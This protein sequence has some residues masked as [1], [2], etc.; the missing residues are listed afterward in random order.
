MDNCRKPWTIYCLATAAILLLVALSLTGVI[1]P[2]P[3]EA[4][5]AERFKDIQELQA[6]IDSH[7]KLATL[8]N[9]NYYFSALGGVLLDTAQ[10]PTVK[11]TASSVTNSAAAP[12]APG[13]AP[14]GAA[15]DFSTTNNQVAGVDEAD[16]VKSDGSYLYVKSGQK[17]DILAAYPPDSAKVLSSLT[18]DNSPVGLFV[19]GSQLLVIS[20]QEPLM[21]PMIAVPNIVAP[22]G[23]AFRPAP[24][25]P[26]LKISV[27]DTA[28]KTAPRLKDSFAITGAD[29]V[30]S[31]MIG[32]YV[33]LIANTPLNLGQYQNDG[34][35]DVRL[36]EIVEGNGGVTT[37]PA[38]AIQHFDIPYPSYNYTM[39]QAYN[40]NALTRKT[41]IFLTG[42]TQQVFVSA[43]NI[44]LTSQDPV[45][46]IPIFQ[47]YLDRLT[48]LLPS[49]LTSQLQDPQIPEEQKLEQLAAVLAMGN[50][51][52]PG[53]QA[54][55]AQVVS[56]LRQDMV[57]AQDQTLVQK[58]R[59]TGYD[60][61]FQVKA[62]VPGQVLNQFSIDEQDG[63]FRIA[64]TT[65]DPQNWNNSSNNIFV[66]GPDL[67]LAGQ[68]TGLAPGEQIYSA[69]FLG[70]RA[71]LVTYKQIDP[72]F[73]VDLADPASPKVLGYLKI[74]GFSDYLH[75]YDD[76][77]I[78]GIGKDTTPNLQE[79]GMPRPTGLKIALFDVTNPEQPRELSRYALPDGSD[80]TALYDHKAFLFSQAKHL[81]ALPVS[82]SQN[83]GSQYSYWQGAYVF[84]I[85][86]DQG[87]TLKGTIDHSDSSQ[88][89]TNNQYLL[90]YQQYGNVQRILY[91]NDVL[92]TV[93]DALVKLNNINSL[94]ELKSLKL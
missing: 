55:I 83:I 43:Q 23:G 60:A 33:Y 40:M 34:Q 30:D 11:S 27:Y 73:V 13:A 67:Q 91:I 4:S 35:N 59:I 28:D 76:N 85:S 68:L 54:E 64:T 42:A 63:Y 39:V 20:Q 44:Y 79:N 7:T 53:N 52:G 93:S 3:V 46:P 81:L 88:L 56:E 16:I 25:S 70:Q 15:T 19:Y 37:F 12:A 47:K 41:S 38:T 8:L 58:F 62:T 71:Y 32:G 24:L 82:S 86:L 22:G 80:S 48:P 90:P 51:T 66:Y 29:Y 17:I 69:R 92:Y 72:F 84:N 21:R 45:D 18:F 77:H 5:G 75:P 9:P 61:V 31:R 2:Q 74:P 89:Q 87:I 57:K 94:A 14:T 26:G 36:P 10:G 49:S 78:I 6:F 1:R 50:N 65:R